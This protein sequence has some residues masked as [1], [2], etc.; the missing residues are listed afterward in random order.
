ME[1]SRKRHASQVKTNGISAATRIA[2]GLFSM[3]ALSTNTRMPH[4]QIN[5]DATYTKQV[6]NLFHEVNKLYDGTLNEVHHLM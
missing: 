2:F 1:E 6:L 4:H 3:F 5:P